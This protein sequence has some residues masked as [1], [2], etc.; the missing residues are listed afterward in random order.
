M[1]IL[2]PTKLYEMRTV[3]EALTFL[4]G[5]KVIKKYKD[6]PD[7]YLIKT[8]SQDLGFHPQRLLFNCAYLL[9]IEPSLNVEA[10][11]P[12]LIHQ[13]GYTL[14]YLR[15]N[16]IVPQ[17]YKDRIS[18]TVADPG[19]ININ[20]WLGYGS[21]VYLSF[22]DE[23]DAVWPEFYAADL[24]LKDALES[25]S[26]IIKE[27]QNGNASTL[28]IGAKGSEICEYSVG[29]HSIQKPVDGV[30]YRSLLSYLNVADKV[31]LTLPTLEQHSITISS[32]QAGA[33]NVILISW[34]TPPKT[35]NIP[36]QHDSN[37]HERS[38]EESMLK[39]ALEMIPFPNVLQ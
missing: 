10:P 39:A 11:S 25:L 35:E 36:L 20:E 7:S 38:F 27:A 6:T 28:I 34:D 8:V 13:I 2:R 17:T 19:M 21:P 4:F 23:V 18:V 31:T 3:R 32:F 22:G 15:T 26:D 37:W 1:T 9:G 14:S 24:N 16:H 29:E 33:R 30:I 5:T 12:E